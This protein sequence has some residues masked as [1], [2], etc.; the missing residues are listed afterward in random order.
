ML[1]VSLDGTSPL[2]LFKGDILVFCKN[3]VV[4]RSIWRS[5]PG[6]GVLGCRSRRASPY[7]D[8][9]LDWLPKSESPQPAYIKIFQYPTT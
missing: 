9:P 5:K 8:T 7:H 3:N 1:H 6:E 2:L 4:Y